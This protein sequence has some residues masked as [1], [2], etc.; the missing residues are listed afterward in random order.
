MNT[1]QPDNIEINIY[2]TNL[3]LNNPSVEP[4]IEQH[5]EN[6]DDQ[7]RQILYE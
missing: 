2:V 6:N 3:L 1:E 5:N 7:S 4:I